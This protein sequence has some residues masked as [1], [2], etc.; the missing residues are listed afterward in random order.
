MFQERIREKYE[1]LTPG[2]RKLADF[3]VDH[4]LDAAFLN[5]TQLARRV[6]LDPATVVRFAQEV[7]YD[8]Y[9]ELSLEIK[10]YMRNQL[11]ANQQTVVE[12]ESD[13]A[14]ILGLHEVTNENIERFL[15]TDTHKLVEA[16]RM[17]RDAAKVWI[18][19]EWNNFALAQFL[20]T[21]LQASGIKA[22]A[23]HA[24]MMS[25]TSALNQMQAGDVLFAITIGVPGVD[26]GYM[27][28]LAREKGVKTVNLS[29]SGVLLAARE[30]D[31]TLA[32]PSTSS[33]GMINYVP[34]LMVIGILW[35]ALAK[36][37]ATADGFAAYN[38]NLGKLL[39]LRSQTEDYEI[40]PPQFD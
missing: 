28:R 1:A 29:H 36:H 35:E 9:R 34:A 7:G 15:A 13:I 21:S 30:A 24:D 17:M 11:T 40:T 12:P 5:A 31:V 25:A 39:A 2:F 10:A 23:I 18:S 19:G 20:A 22:A 3:I 16:V 26:C 37:A 33:V 32:V 6:G 4:T 27:L 38:D 8:G 14:F